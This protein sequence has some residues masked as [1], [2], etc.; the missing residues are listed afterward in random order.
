MLHDESFITGLLIG[1]DGAWNKAACNS[2]DLGAGGKCDI[3]KVPTFTDIP[4]DGSLELTSQNKA[5][6]SFWRLAYIA[7]VLSQYGFTRAEALNYEPGKSSA[8]STYTVNYLVL[9]NQTMDPYTWVHTSTHGG[10]SVNFASDPCWLF[11]SGSLIAIIS[12]YDKYSLPY[13]AGGFIYT[14]NQGAGEWKPFQSPLMTNLWDYAM[15]GTIPDITADN[16]TFHGD[17]FT[18]VESA[19]NNKKALC[20]DFWTISGTTGFKKDDVKACPTFDAVGQ[21][22]EIN[23]R[24]VVYLCH[25]FG[26]DVSNRVYKNLFWL[27]PEGVTS[28]T[29][30]GLYPA[31]YCT[32]GA[33]N[34]DAQPDY[35]KGSYYDGYHTGVEAGASGSGDYDLGYQQGYSKGY[36]EGSAAGDAAGYTRGYDEGFT[37]GHT[38]GD[39][40]GYTRGYNEGYQKGY[41][42]GQASSGGS[43]TG[44]QPTADGATELYISIVSTGRL[45]QPLCFSQTVSNGVTINW[46]D[47][48]TETL[49]GTGVLTTQHTYAEIGDYCI[50]LLPAEG[51]TLGLGGDTSSAKNVFG[52]G[53][54]ANEAAY[55]SCQ[56]VKAVVGSNV[57]RL[58]RYAFRNCYGLIECYIMEGCAEIG[59]GAFQ[60]DNAL[61]KVHLPE[62]LTSMADGNAFYGCTGLSEVNFPAA[63]A[64]LGAST[65]RNAA[66]RAVKLDAVTS[67][68]N[69]CFA[70][71]YAL[72]VADLPASLTSLGNY[73]FQNCYNLLEVHCRASTPP[74]VTSTT[75]TGDASDV[76]YYVPAGSMG[77]YQAASY[78]KAVNLIGE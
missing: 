71:D 39:A 64:G 50:R 17:N 43:D 32:H 25:T 18:I 22:I 62:T 35:T 30:R 28:P 47:G 54:S 21:V 1:Q 7:D 53:T 41:T 15:N 5:V 38:A 49:A 73:I 3:W 51:C 68:G 60:S 48:T 72:Q 74:S 52:A 23:G 37:I 2:F 4:V 16:I 20:S 59:N 46:G 44:L 12:R 76:T 33:Y 29:W 77:A 42:D 14:Q 78:W 45:T 9:D 36:T 58:G 13:I 6:W 61:R 24:N 70:D 55:H 56:L 10:A 75:F 57:P 69:Y 63:L 34:E 40:E 65:F 66:V 67:I 11:V 27:L 8:S 19:I 31:K 26:M